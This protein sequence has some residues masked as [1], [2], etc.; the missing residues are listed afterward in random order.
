VSDVDFLSGER[1]FGRGATKAGRGFWWVWRE[2]GALVGEGGRTRAARFGEWGVGDGAVDS[3][4]FDGVEDCVI[5]GCSRGGLLGGSGLEG[6]MFG[7]GGMVDDVSGTGMPGES[8]FGDCIFE[9]LILGDISPSAGVLIECSTGDAFSG[10]CF[11]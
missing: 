7:D 10:G 3:W 5:G 4:G 1:G 9:V 8:C 6:R 2:E 11:S